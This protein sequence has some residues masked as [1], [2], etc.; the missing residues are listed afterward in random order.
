[1]YAELGN[2]E[3]QDEIRSRRPNESHC[4]W[5]LRD[6]SACESLPAGVDGIKAGSVCPHNVYFHHADAF[7]SR[8]AA[9]DTL[10][11]IFRLITAA[12]LGLKMD[13]DILTTSELIAAKNELN[14]QEA[15]RM[16]ESRG[17]SSDN[18]DAG[19][20]GGR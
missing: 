10:D 11:R 6:P 15:D 12:D 19:L 2:K 18:V 1:L 3:A 16:R 7:Q 8:D 20:H 14:K 9:A 5:L 13:L 4:R 17:K